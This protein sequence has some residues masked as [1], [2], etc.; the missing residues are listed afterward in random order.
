MPSPFHGGLARHPRVFPSH[1]P[2][3]GRKRLPLR[4]RPS[5]SIP[6]PPWLSQ[7]RRGPCSRGEPE[8]GGKS[9]FW[10]LSEKPADSARGPSDRGMLPSRGT[11]GRVSGRNR[12]PC[13]SARDEQDVVGVRT[14]LGRPLGDAV[15]ATYVNG[16]AAPPAARVTTSPP[17][18]ARAPHGIGR[19]QPRQT[20]SSCC[21][22]YPAALPSKKGG[23]PFEIAPDQGFLLGRQQRKPASRCQGRA[24]SAVS[25]KWRRVP[26]VEPAAVS[27]SPGALRVLRVSVM[28]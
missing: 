5:P 11:G 21:R 8:H 7:A 3:H 13:D 1:Q 2:A 16:V 12:C 10:P 26:V 19:N 22:R 27:I 25:R 20:C 15:G 18:P 6:E 28:R 23:C 14:P 4:P 9:A 17:V 24:I